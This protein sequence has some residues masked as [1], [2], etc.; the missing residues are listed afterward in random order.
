MSA[1]EAADD[2]LPIGEVALA[3]AALEDETA[4]LPSYHSFLDMVVR[5]MLRKGGDLTQDNPTLDEQILLLRNTL[6]HH[7]GFMGDRDSYNSLENANL[8]RVID[9]RKGLPVALGILYLHIA[10]KL[11]WNMVGLSFPGHFLLR[12]ET[13]GE[14]AILDPFDN[15]VVRHT[16]DLRELLKSTQ[17]EE[18]ELLPEHY[19]PVS[20]RQVLLR[21]QNNIKMRHLQHGA[22]EKAIDV[23]QSMVLFAPHEAMLWRELGLFHG[24]LGNF[25]SAIS[26]LETFMK[27]GVPESLK[28]QTAL[29]LQKMR[30]GLQ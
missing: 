17:G 10:R 7:Y 6:V 2:H 15:C 29:I 24:K 19:E 30:A 3:L 18:A 20:D 25:K 9:R 14:R 12:L 1:G 21:L 22:L 26:A 4:A 23:L 28:H 11:K 13:G 8:M 27:L 16:I 5:D